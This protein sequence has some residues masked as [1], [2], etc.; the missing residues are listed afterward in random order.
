[1]H[2]V[3]QTLVV[4]GSDLTLSMVS[5]MFRYNNR[6]YHTVVNLPRPLQMSADMKHV[7][8]TTARMAFLECVIIHINFM[9]GS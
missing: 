3:E 1:M 7:I 6:L 8:I 9:Y 2:E 5:Q 4:F